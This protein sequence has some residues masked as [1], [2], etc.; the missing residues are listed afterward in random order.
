MTVATCHP[1]QPHL[2]KGLCG[3]CYRAVYAR[4]YR[5]AHKAEIAE[6]DRARDWRALYLVRK[7]RHAEYRR[8]HKAQRAERWRA[9][10]KANPEKIGALRSRRRAAELGAGGSVTAAQWR[11]IQGAYAGRCAYC[12]EKPAS[13][14]QDHVIPLSRGGSHTPENIVPACVSCNSRKGARPPTRLPTKR[15]LF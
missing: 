2:A 15:L 3:V 7:D 8:T 11:A 10:K 1:D 14:T 6:Y 13:L 4:A 12:G 5:I 9:W